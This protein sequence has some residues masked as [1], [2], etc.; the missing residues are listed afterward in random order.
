MCVCMQAK[1]CVT[2]ILPRINTH[3]IILESHQHALTVLFS[4]YEC[5][6]LKGGS[7]LFGCKA[8]RK[9]QKET[10]TYHM[11]VYVC[12]CILLHVLNFVSSLCTFLSSP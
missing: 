2:L 11:C 7:Y 5:L 12:V 3:N 9:R 1:A 8:E 6:T 10:H 4:P